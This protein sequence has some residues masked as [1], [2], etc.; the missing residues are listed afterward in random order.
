LKKAGITLPQRP[1]NGPPGGGEGG[2]GGFFFGGGPPG[3]GTARSGDFSKIQAALKKCGINP[4]RRRG[5]FN[6]ANNPRFK[7]ALDKFV[8]C[9]RKN[10]YDL[11]AP[12]TSGKGPVFDTSKVNRNDPKFKKAAAKC[13]SDLQALRPQG[14]Q[15]QPPPAN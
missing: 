11:P 14:T 3:G 10:G 6:I 8:A 5:N 2:A 1:A 15:G 9:V 13:Q 12:N 4:V 7:Q